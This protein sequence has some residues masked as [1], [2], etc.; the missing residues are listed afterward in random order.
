MTKRDQ[1]SGTLIALVVVVAI[2]AEGSAR[3]VACKNDPELAGSCFTF[4]GRLSVANGNP[5]ARILHLG[6]NRLLGVSEQHKA[7]MP[8]ALE[9]RLT[10]DDTVE[11]TFTVCPFTPSQPGAMQLVCIEAAS[12]LTLER[13]VDGK[14]T[15]VKIPDASGS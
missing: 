8:R 10:W 11:G 1:A 5:S 6:T 7:Y 9:A 2:C 4:R 15:T 3:E 12:A 14:R 13:K